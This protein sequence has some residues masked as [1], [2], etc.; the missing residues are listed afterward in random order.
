MVRTRIRFYLDEHLAHAIAEA[1]RRR[2]VDVAT[3]A[4]VGR[5]GLSDV[6]QLNWST[7]QNRVLVSRDPDYLT[8][9][10]DHP[11]H[12]G[13]VYIPR[14]IDVRAVIRGLLFIH[15]N[16]G[17]RRDGRTTGIPASL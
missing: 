12:F 2:D 10:T 14:K 9:H 16:P 8:L 6:E 13:I 15:A 17:G 7:Q 11:A 5:R 3:V 1:L 4:D